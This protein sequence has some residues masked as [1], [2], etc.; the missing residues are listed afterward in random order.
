M[1]RVSEQ[2]ARAEQRFER[3]ATYLTL[4]HGNT[5]PRFVTH[6]LANDVH[7]SGA[8]LQDQC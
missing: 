5:S 2:L 1:L 8:T 7:H 4:Y 6:A 3:W